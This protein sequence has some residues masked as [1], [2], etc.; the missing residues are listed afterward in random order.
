MLIKEEGN[1]CENCGEC[2]CFSCKKR[3]RGIGYD[4][5]ASSCGRCDAGCEDKPL[6]DCQD[7]EYCDY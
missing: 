5:E 3:E 1:T 4:V 6:D 7:F 2:K